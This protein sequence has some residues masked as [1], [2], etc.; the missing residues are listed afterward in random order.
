MEYEPCWSLTE[1]QVPSPPARRN[2]ID[3]LRWALAVIDPDDHGQM[4]FL[5]GCLAY[6]LGNGGGLTEKQGRVCQEIV[7]K[8][9]ADWEIGALA[10][11]L[12]PDDDDEDDG[13]VHLADMQPEGSA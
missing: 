7:R 10:C 9:T 8:I 4:K 13:V 3:V 6:A 5:A 11:Q 2:A 12:T 1:S